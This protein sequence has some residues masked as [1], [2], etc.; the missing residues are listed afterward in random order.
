MDSASISRWTFA[1]GSGRLVANSTND[2]SLTISDG[3]TWTPGP[4]GAGAVQLDGR[5]SHL[6]SEAPVLDT[7]SAFSVAVW[8]R[9]DS[10]VRPN[11][12]QLP[13]DEYALT[14]LSQCG[15]T[16]DTRTHC[17]FYIGVRVLDDPGGE[18]SRR[19]LH[20]CLNVAPSDG[21]VEQRE[22]E[23]V[24]VFSPE[25]VHQADLDVWVPL[26][27][28]VDFG[29]SLATLQV[30]GRY[31]SRVSTSLPSGWPL[32]KAEGPLIAG[33]AVWLG[34]KVDPWPGAIGPIWAQPGVFD[35]SDIACILAGEI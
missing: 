20:W 26:I 10:S 18:S 27:G 24:K 8:V 19:P 21:S 32:W 29:H 23:W 16:W 9:L 33:A 35:E 25:P 11:L 15:P 28:I 14:A 2:I 7:A 1:E 31:G 17:P 6:V 3:A 5:G 30:G 4:H 34:G 22:F 13:G 12:L